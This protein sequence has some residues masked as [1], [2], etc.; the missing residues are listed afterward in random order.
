MNKTADDVAKKSRIFDKQ[1]FGILF[2]FSI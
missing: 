2:P 1:R